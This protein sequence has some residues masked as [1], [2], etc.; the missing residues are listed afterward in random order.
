MSE[1]LEV[2]ADYEVRAVIRFLNHKKIRPTEIHRQ[3]VEVYGPV[4]SVQ[5]VRKWCREFLSGRTNLEDEQR[6]GRP[7][8]I[9]DELVRRIDEIL[10]SDRR[11]TISDLLDQFPS[12][13]RGTM[14]SIVHDKLNFRKLC[15]RWVPKLLTEEHKVQRM[16][17]SLE[18]LTRFHEEENE[19][20]D[21][22]VT[23]DETWVF[24]DTP[25]TKRMS[26]QWKH[27]NSPGIVKAKQT[28]TRKKLMATVFW[29]SKGFLLV[30]FM[31]PGTTINGERYRQTLTN[32]RRA[33]QNKRR[34]KLTQGI[35]LL[36]DNARPHSAR[37]TCNLIA[38]FGWNALPHPAYSPDLAPSDFHLFPKLKKDI[39]GSR[40]ETDEEL[41][42]FVLT[43]LENLAA[44][45]YEEG[46]YKL[47]SRLDKC[48][49]L[50]GE[51]V[52]K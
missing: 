38:Q 36:H 1:I 30:E 35:E 21:K 14:H 50:K 45:D 39:A 2:T 6:S 27:T 20:L 7:S 19:F 51:Y 33:I 5:H 23:G 10:R 8:V 17:S 47:I 29:D 44:S 13:S 43:W 25:E 41:K 49:N 37:E 42:N 52:E 22:I 31:K 12:V 28:L 16:G 18:I 4:M 40:F 3:I 15:A 11:Q 46:I 48:L 26:M 9:S 24:H 32:L 34:G